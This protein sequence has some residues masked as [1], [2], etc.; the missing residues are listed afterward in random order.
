VCV[1][2]LLSNVK[3][4]TRQTEN[5][6][7]VKTTFVSRSHVKCVVKYLMLQK[8]K[9]SMLQKRSFDHL[10]PYAI[11]GQSLLLVVTLYCHLQ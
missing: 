5:N 8:Q 9:Y 2:K 7:T 11:I 10:V 3:G 4:A 6:H 1:E